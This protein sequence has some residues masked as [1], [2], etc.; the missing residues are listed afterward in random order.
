M[1]WEWALPHRIRVWRMKGMKGQLSPELLVVAGVS[2]GR[3]GHG[4]TGLGVLVMAET[5]S[6][7]GRGRGKRGRVR[8]SR[9]VH[10]SGFLLQ[11]FISKCVFVSGYT[12]PC[13]SCNM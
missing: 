9:A 13:I 5:W 8:F 2:R 3:V 7:G 12:I 4:W 6:C 10:I 1:D 11:S